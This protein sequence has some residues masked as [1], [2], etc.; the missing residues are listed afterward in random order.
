[1]IME[2][3]VMECGFSSSPASQTSFYLGQGG[4]QLCILVLVHFSMKKKIYY[5][6]ER[7]L[8]KRP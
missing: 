5:L 2:L 3:K 6:I 4:S 7:I 1:M 8:V